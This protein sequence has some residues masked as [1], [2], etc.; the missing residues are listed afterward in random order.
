MSPRPDFTTMNISLRRAQKS[1]VD[2]RV[3]GGGYG[4]VSD[5]IRELIRRDQKDQN[6]AALEQRL[7]EAMDSPTSEMT[8]EDWAR[9][10]RSV[11]ERSAERDAG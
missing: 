2:D 11:L 9:I 6:R 3:A 4:S 5:Y 7:L 1:Y 10:R 8:A